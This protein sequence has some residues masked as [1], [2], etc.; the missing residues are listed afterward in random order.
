MQV[1]PG[2]HHSVL[3]GLR[4]Q[5]G[6]ERFVGLLFLFLRTEGKERRGGSG[7]DNKAEREASLVAGPRER[8]VP[9]LTLRSFSS[10]CRLAEIAV[11]A[12]AR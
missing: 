8:E 12:G 2:V 1:F 11:V 6:H 9:L 10:V 5:P 4:T 3:L 7:S